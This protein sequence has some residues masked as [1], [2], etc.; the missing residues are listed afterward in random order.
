[1]TVQHHFGSGI[2]FGAGLYF[3]FAEPAVGLGLAV[4]CTAAAS[5][6][7]V[8]EASVA[9]CVN[10]GIGPFPLAWDSSAVV[11][12]GPLR[13]VQF[14]VLVLAG[15]GAAVEGAAALGTSV[16]NPSL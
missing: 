10:A 6:V 3:S 1:M 2:W 12:V 8:S 14:A 5:A 4:D 9:R 11:S 13:A 15:N 7:R 16:G